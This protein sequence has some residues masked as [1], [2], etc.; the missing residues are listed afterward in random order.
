M[1]AI[2]GEQRTGTTGL[3]SALNCHN[4]IKMFGELFLDQPTSYESFFKFWGEKIA[5][6]P[7]NAF[8]KWDRFSALLD[9]FI[10][11]L[12]GTTEKKVIGFQIKYDQLSMVPHLE[13]WL[14]TRG[15]KVIHIKRRSLLATYVSQQSLLSRF[16]A[17]LTAHTH[18]DDEAPI[19]VDVPSEI[20]IRSALGE[21]KARIERGEQD[22]SCLQRIDLFYEDVYGEHKETDLIRIQQFLEV[23]P[24][25]INFQI[26]KSIKVHLADIMRQPQNSEVIKRLIEEESA[27]VLNGNA[28]KGGNL[29]THASGTVVLSFASQPPAP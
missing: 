11:E 9:E 23:D 2:V 6:D 5:Q 28:P 18:T 10:G 22:L 12:R 4:D 3:G 27:G 20:Q 1:F 21:I 17:G 16:K 29:Q 26:L 13:P 14:R 15:V 8:P 25:E 7:M 24:I 19:L